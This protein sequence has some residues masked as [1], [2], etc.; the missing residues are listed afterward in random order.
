M[1]AVGSGVGRGAP[2]VIARLALTRGDLEQRF[3]LRFAAVDNDVSPAVIALGRLAD[4]T[5][6]GFAVVEL[7]PAGGVELVQFGR[8]EPAGV[9]DEVLSELGLTRRQVSWL[10]PP[11]GEP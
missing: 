5:L 3:G 6:V 1:E 10:L 7:D 11:R 8:R 9:L 4:G 2:E